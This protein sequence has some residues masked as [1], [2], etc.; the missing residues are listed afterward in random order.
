MEIIN[1]TINAIKQIKGP[2]YFRNEKK[3][4][5]KFHSQLKQQLKGADLF[6]RGTQLEIFRPESNPDYPMLRTRSVLVLHIPD[7]KGST[8]NTNENN[9]V[10]FAFYS[11]R[12]QI[13]F[14]DT[15]YTLYQMFKTLDYKTGIII[16]VGNYPDSYLITSGHSF[17]DR[18]HELSIGYND[19]NAVI[20]HTHYKNGFF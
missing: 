7:K 10:V 20:Q 3:F 15:N 6:P 8:Q 18:T 11:G 2:D 13:K 12:G 4:I 9:F 16:N 14:R 17:P 19:G 5:A 1:L